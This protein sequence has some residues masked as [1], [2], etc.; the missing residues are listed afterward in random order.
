MKNLTT[1]LIL[2]A[3]SL[4]ISSCQKDDKEDQNE[5]QMPVE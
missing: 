2:I 1:F 4:L 3:I 5:P